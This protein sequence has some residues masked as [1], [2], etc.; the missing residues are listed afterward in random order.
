METPHLDPWSLFFKMINDIHV[1]YTNCIKGSNI[2]A[3]T[4]K[5]GIVAMTF[6]L[7]SIL[8]LGGSFPNCLPDIPTQTTP[9]FGKSSNRR[10]KKST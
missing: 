1:V 2:F 10:N 3:C 5:P 7:R 9:A 8:S 4:C 6:N